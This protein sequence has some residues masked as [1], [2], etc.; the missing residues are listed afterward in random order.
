MRISHATL[1]VVGGIMGAFFKGW[2][3]KVGVLT[4]VMALILTRMWIRSASIGD[5]LTFPIGT[6]WDDCVASNNQCLV[7]GR[8][9]PD[10]RPAH[11]P[12]PQWRTIPP[13][14]WDDPPNSDVRW[15]YLGFGIVD[16]NNERLSY[17]LIPYW[18]ITIPLTL[19]SAFLLLTKPHKSTT[20]KITEP[21]INEGGGA[22]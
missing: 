21:T 20:K 10:F 3:R 16:R 15:R 9:R 1:L 18:S 7:W 13:I 2:K 14:N 8:Y 17:L 5:E 19:I 6:Q 11:R 12:F 4:L 22:L